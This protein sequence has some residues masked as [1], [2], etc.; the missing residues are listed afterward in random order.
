MVEGGKM[1]DEGV[2]ERMKMH[3]K[4]KENAWKIGI[5][6]RM[7]IFCSIFVADY[8]TEDDNSYY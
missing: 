3:G 7:S 2:K 6:L 8:G 4:C 5:Y 1:K